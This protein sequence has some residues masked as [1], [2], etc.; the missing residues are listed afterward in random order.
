VKGDHH[1]WGLCEQSDKYGLIIGETLVVKGEMVLVGEMDLKIGEYFKVGEELNVLGNTGGQYWIFMFKSD[2]SL[3]IF[4]QQS[5]KTTRETFGKTFSSL[6]IEISPSLNL[7][8]LELITTLSLSSSHLFISPRPSESRLF[9]PNVE[10]L[11]KSTS[12]FISKF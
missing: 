3:L 8:R 5:L 6:S 12:T 1:P 4:S 10:K 11:H 2:S 9:P 7:T